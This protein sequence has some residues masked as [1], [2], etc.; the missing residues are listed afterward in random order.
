MDIQ[1]I[2][3]QTKVLRVLYMEGYLKLQSPNSRNL[4]MKWALPNFLSYELFYTIRL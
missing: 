1:F 4:E 2:V 3:D